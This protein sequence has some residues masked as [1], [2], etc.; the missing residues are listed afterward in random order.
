VRVHEAIDLYVLSHCHHQS[1]VVACIRRK[2]PK[3]IAYNEKRNISF[4]SASED[5]VT[6]RFDHFS[7]RDYK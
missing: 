6:G 3:G 4:I 1:G 7:V 2:L 5:L